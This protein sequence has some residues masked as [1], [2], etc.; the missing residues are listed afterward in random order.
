ME[1]MESIITLISEPYSQRYR[2]LPESVASRRREPGQDHNVAHATPH[3]T[4]MTLNEL[5]NNEN[6]LRHSLSRYNL[7]VHVEDPGTWNTYMRVGISKW[8]ILRFLPR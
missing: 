3:I 2:R 6:D 5:V 7:K 1:M 4:R 8:V